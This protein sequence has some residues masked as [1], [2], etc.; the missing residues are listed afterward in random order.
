MGEGQEEIGPR[1]E[2]IF[3]HVWSDHVGDNRWEARLDLRT[4]GEGRREKSISKERRNL[5]GETVKCCILIK[6]VSVSKNGDKLE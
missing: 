1:C 2:T 4:K 3:F 6:S 5:W